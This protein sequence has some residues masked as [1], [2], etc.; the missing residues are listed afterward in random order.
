ME[1]LK[2]LASI[3]HEDILG[4]EVDGKFHPLDQDGE[5]HIHGGEAFRS[6][7]G[8]VKITINSKPYETHPG[9]NTVT[10]LRNLGH[11]P[12][13]EILSEFQDG[14]FID[15]AENAS[16]NIQGGEIFASHRPTGG[17]S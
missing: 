5:V 3:P 13:D 4:K 11:V 6:H 15:L 9:E 7:K 14:R 2:K 12:A 17:S 16:V 10:H 8:L 1:H